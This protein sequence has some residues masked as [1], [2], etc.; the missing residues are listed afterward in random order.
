MGF[1]PAPPSDC[2]HTHTKGVSPFSSCSG[3]APQGQRGAVSSIEAHGEAQRA[4]LYSP[5]HLDEGFTS[6]GAA[7][8]PILFPHLKARFLPGANSTLPAAPQRAVLSRHAR[9]S[10]LTSWHSPHCTVCPSQPCP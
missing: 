7:Q 3:S 4:P 8:P 2:P 10:S 6:F 9:P 1:P 5:P